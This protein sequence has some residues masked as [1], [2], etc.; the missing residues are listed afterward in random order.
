MP[1][2]PYL[3]VFNQF[4]LAFEDFN[5]GNGIHNSMPSKFLLTLPLVIHLTCWFF[6]QFLFIFA[7]LTGSK[8]HLLPTW[9]K[10]LLRASANLYDSHLLKSL[11]FHPNKG[12]SGIYFKSAVQQTFNGCNDQIWTR[13]ERQYLFSVFQNFKFHEIYGVGQ[14]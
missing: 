13:M 6:F 3:P 5:Y 4:L 2:P 14:F 12:T 9:P 11:T 8:F 10:L 7:T 1:N